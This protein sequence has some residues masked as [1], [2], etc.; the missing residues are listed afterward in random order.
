M[1]PTH[2]CPPHTQIGLQPPPAAVCISER[3]AAARSLQEDV[4]VTSL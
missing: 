3:A 4:V 1:M 2:T